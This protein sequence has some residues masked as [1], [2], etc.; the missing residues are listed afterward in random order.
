MVATREGALQLV[1]QK[2]I[3]DSQHVN[4]WLVSHGFAPLTVNEEVRIQEG[5]P[6][7]GNPLIDF[8]KGSGQ[9]LKDIVSGITTAGS[10]INRYA[11][12]PNFRDI[13]NRNIAQWYNS[14]SGIEKIKDIYNALGHPVGLDTENLGQYLSDPGRAAQTTLARIGSNPVDAYLLGG[15]AIGAKAAKAMRLP[16]VGD[17]LE[18]VKAPIGIRQ[19][20]PSQKV[21]QVNTAINTARGNINA[22]ILENSKELTEAMSLP[23]STGEALRAITMGTEVPGEL[24]PKVDALKKVFDTHQELLAKNY[25]IPKEQG[26]TTASMQRMMEIIN[27]DRTLPVDFTTISNALKGDVQAIQATGKTSKEL[28]TMFKEGLNLANEG[29][30]KPITQRYFYD[31]PSMGGLDPRV[32]SGVG[33]AA[34]RRYGWATPEQLTNTLVKGYEDTLRSAMSTKAGVTSV[35]DIA[36]QVGRKVA[37]K[38]ELLNDE[39]LISP[40]AFAEA[41]HNDVIN[42]HLGTMKSRVEDLMKGLREDVVPLYSD[43]LYAIKKDHLRPLLNSVSASANNRFMG[44]LD[45]VW[46]YNALGSPQ[47]LTGNRFGN[48]VGRMLM[49]GNPLKTIKDY[50]DVKPEVKFKGKTIM[51]GGK[52]REQIPQLLKAQTSYEGVLGR[53][54]AGKT[55][56]DAEKRALQETS[57]AI[58]NSDWATAFAGTN[59]IFGSPLMALEAGMETT[60]RSAAFLRI[61]KRIAKEENK[62]TEQ[63]LKQAS[64]D[65]AMFN[66]IND[67]IKNFFGDYAGRNWNIDPRLYGGLSLTFPFFKF[68]TQSLRVANYAAT[69]KPTTFIPQVLLPGELGRKYWDKQKQTLGYNPEELGGVAYKDKGSSDWRLQRFTF[70]PI[71]A[72]GEFL[73]NVFNRPSNINISPLLSLANVW[74][75]RNNYGQMMSGPYY[76][77]SGGVTHILDDNGNPTG[78]IKTEPSVADILQAVGSNLANQYVYPIGAWNRWVGPAITETIDKWN[79]KPEWNTWYPRYDTTL[80]GQIGS[81]RFTNP[82]YSGKID[83]RGKK[84]PEAEWGKVLGN[85]YTQLYEPRERATSRQM[86]QLIRKI[87]KERKRK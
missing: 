82:I 10:A 21:A 14:R 7:G 33:P 60:D 47:Y 66:R 72:G 20:V 44:A 27:P 36:N 29:K 22:S 12:D 11:L 43:D 28:N 41:I 30:I 5:R 64:E 59:K 83:T 85:Q 84:Y 46:K 39:I 38:S 57:D 37:N 81:R 63:I 58:K 1:T 53:E 76:K 16:T 13:A 4:N 25:N 6:V 87:N 31:T 61:A 9:S 78:R 3:R 67:E 42:K 54:F 70:S 74:N 55:I 24:Q 18:T 77:T 52:Y 69:H 34:Q 50:W 17:V 23:G 2:G 75:F 65:T 40:R 48:F 51:P 26:A 79:I 73:Y 80:L 19:F 86:R 35:Q 68:P 62:T 49:E 56:V 8:A 15:G 71:T 45:S 32:P